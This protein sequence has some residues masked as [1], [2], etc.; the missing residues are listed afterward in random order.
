MR[1]TSKGWVNMHFWY[2]TTCKLN[3]VYSL[4]SVREVGLFVG[5]FR[6]T[7]TTFSR[8]PVGN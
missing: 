2:S 6:G 1:I 7:Y 5:I 8:R 4:R 3:A